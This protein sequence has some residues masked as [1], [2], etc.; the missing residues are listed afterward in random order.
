RLVQILINILG[1]A[2]KFTPRRGRIDL[3]IGLT[4]DKTNAFEQLS[5]KIT[6]TGPGIPPEL[7]DQVF[8]PFTQGE[9][10]LARDH[11]G[12]GLGLPLSR[13]LAILLGG[14]LWLED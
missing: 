5:F 13:E 8:E 2:V 12:T 7:R 4:Q 9:N 10:S 3:L 6:D 14:Q 1:N 11:D